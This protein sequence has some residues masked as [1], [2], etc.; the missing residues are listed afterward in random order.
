MTLT[1]PAGTTELAYTQI[2]NLDYWLNKLKSEGYKMGLIKT[3]G[4]EVHV[5]ENDHEVATISVRNGKI[6]SRHSVSK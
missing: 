4:M 6:V 1:V 2:D 3:A 5:A